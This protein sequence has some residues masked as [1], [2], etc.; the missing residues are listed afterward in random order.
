MILAARPELR[1]SLSAQNLPSGPD[2]VKR[3]ALTADDGRQPSVQNV[4]A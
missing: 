3:A 4:L 1:P 2:V